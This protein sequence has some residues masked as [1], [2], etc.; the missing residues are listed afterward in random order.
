MRH[1]AQE[2]R[3]AGRHPSAE[4][5]WADL[6]NAGKNQTSFMCFCSRLFFF[7]LNASFIF[8]YSGFFQRSFSSWMFPAKLFAV[9]VGARP[10]PSVGTALEHR[11]RQAALP[12]VG[13]P[14]VRVRR[15]SHGTI[16]RF[17]GGLLWGNKTLSENHRFEWGNKNIYKY[18]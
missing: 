12:Q 9:D 7:P 10:G 18:L 3:L 5:A 15:K 13:T 11:R 4:D 17:S 1:N 16:P 6:E 14:T 8:I 2:A